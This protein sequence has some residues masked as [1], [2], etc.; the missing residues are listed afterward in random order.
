MN[1]KFS[2]E[3]FLLLR[4][5]TYSQ[6]GLCARQMY[7]FS[8]HSKNCHK[9]QYAANISYSYYLFNLTK[10]VHHSEIFIKVIQ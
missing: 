8:I 7:S 2:F 5:K 3:Y 10:I 9:F 6:A 1:L 4:I